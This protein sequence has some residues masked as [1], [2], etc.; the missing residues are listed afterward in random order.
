MPPVSLLLI[1]YPGRCRHQQRYQTRIERRRQNVIAKRS[2]DVATS[3]TVHMRDGL[4]LNKLNSINH[5][6]QVALHPSA[7]PYDFGLQFPDVALEQGG[8][9][10]LISGHI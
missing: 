4:Q 2:R 9:L 8:S 3:N 1:Q 5:S 10:T 6:G 7:D